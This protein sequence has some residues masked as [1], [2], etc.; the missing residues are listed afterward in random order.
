M[1]RSEIDST[2]SITTIENK[3]AREMLLTLIKDESTLQRAKAVSEGDYKKLFEEVFRLH[4]KG[5]NEF[6]PALVDNLKNIDKCF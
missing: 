5:H 1:T 2:E 3:E 6:L 4:Q